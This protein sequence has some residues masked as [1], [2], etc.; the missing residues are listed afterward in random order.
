MSEFSPYILFR[1]GTQSFIQ[2][3]N[4]NAQPVWDLIEEFQHRLLVQQKVADDLGNK[5]FKV[6]PTLDDRNDRGEVIS[7]R[8]RIHKLTTFNGVSDLPKSVASL[9]Y[10]VKTF[11]EYLSISNKQTHLKQQNF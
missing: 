4:F 2:L 7:F 5:L 10:I 9:S 3:E 8:R 11:E 1:R 6:I